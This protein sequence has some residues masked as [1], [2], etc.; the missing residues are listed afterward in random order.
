MFRIELNLVDRL[1]SREGN[2][3]ILPDEVFSWTELE[4]NVTKAV[5]RQREVDG[6]TTRA[7]QGVANGSEPNRVFSTSRHIMCSTANRTS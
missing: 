6:P 2:S 4:T 1:W 3:L 7:C 5:H